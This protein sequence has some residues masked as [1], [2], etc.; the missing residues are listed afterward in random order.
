MTKSK[1]FYAALL[2]GVG[3]LAIAIVPHAK[4]DKESVEDSSFFRGHSASVEPLKE[5]SQ[6]R[7]DTVIDQ[8]L[9][10]LKE[11]AFGEQ[12]IF[13]NLSTFEPVMN[14]VKKGVVSFERK[15]FRTSNY[16]DEGGYDLIVYEV[17][18]PL[19]TQSRV[20]AYFERKLGELPILKIVFLTGRP[21]ESSGE[22]V[23]FANGIVA[24]HKDIAWLDAQSIF[25]HELSDASSLMNA[26]VH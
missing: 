4:F 2:C 8:F 23:E 9:G 25:E 11:D 20:M 13:A 16:H 6:L 21:G 26:S 24:S 15:T 17:H 19:S 1:N 7:K 22:L 12:A 14:I 3:V 18:H 10:S 5:I